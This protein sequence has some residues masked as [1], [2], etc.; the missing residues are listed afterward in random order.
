MV[1]STSLCY[2]FD[3][4]FPVTDSI[5]H[6]RSFPNERLINLA[7]SFAFNPQGPSLR[8]NSSPSQEEA[9]VSAAGSGAADGAESDASPSAVE[10]QSPAEDLHALI[11]AKFFER[12][13]SSASGPRVLLTRPAK[14]TGFKLLPSPR[15]QVHLSSGKTFSIS[16][17]F[18]YLTNLFC[19]LFC[20]MPCLETW[21]RP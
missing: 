5:C 11:E 4:G 15:Q 3:V 14:K 13:R 18:S 8:P 17:S 7:P 21:T 1:A 6:A 9:V 12:R 2:A 10:N 16:P 20:L 19:L